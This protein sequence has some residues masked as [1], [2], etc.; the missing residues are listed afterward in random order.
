MDESARL[1]ATVRGI[2]QGVFFRHH[3]KLEA[4][5]LGLSGTVRNCPDGTV[6]VVAEGTRERLNQFLQWL[7]QGPS[8][9]AVDRVDA[10]WS[11]ETGPYRDFRIM[12]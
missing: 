7:H 1:E 5:R 2:V 3:T 4:D 11:A 9:A 8:L 6:A 12:V 10:T